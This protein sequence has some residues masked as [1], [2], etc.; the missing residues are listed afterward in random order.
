MEAVAYKDPLVARLAAGD[1]AAYTECYNA[2]R[3]R[4]FGFLA[5]LAGNRAVAE[6]LLQDTFMKLARH[7]HALRPDTE[8]AAWL[9][10]V[11]RNAATSH[12]RWARL[13]ATRILIWG[14]KPETVV[15]TP[16]DLAAANATERRVEAA[17]AKLSQSDREVLLLVAAEDFS[18]QQAAEILGIGEAACRQRLSRARQRLQAL[19]DEGV[20]P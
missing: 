1:R 3:P 15:L 5:R 11:A 6:E 10:T 12:R 9:F 8:I 13:D 7:A 19:L 14:S 20:K 16:E 17:I 4:L 2:L 18:P